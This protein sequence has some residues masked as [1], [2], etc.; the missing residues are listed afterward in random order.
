MSVNQTTENLV[1]Q[2]RLTLIRDPKVSWLMSLLLGSVT[3][4][5]DVTD[6]G[7]RNPTLCVTSKTFYINGEYFTGLAPLVRCSALLHEALHLALKHV[8][9]YVDFPDHKRFNYACDYIVNPMIQ[10]LGYPLHPTWLYEEKYLNKTLKFIYDDLEE[11]GEDDGDDDSGGGLGQCMFEPTPIDDIPD[12]VGRVHTAMEILKGNPTAM[13]AVSKVLDYVQQ[14]ANP[15]LPFK[16][17]LSDYLNMLS[18]DERTW[19]YPNRRMFAAGILSKGYGYGS[20]RSA[21]VIFD[22]SASMNDKLRAL[23]IEQIEYMRDA[24]KIQE[25]TVIVFSDE[26]NQVITIHEGTPITNEDLYGGGGTNM[27]APFDKIEELQLTP[28]IA[29]VFTDMEWTLPP[30]PNYDVLWVGIHT[31]PY[32]LQRHTNDPLFYGKYLELI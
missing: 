1:T 7:Q 19:R 32:W 11:S 28:E 18:M 9:R 27:Q 30:K 23:A 29:M 26:V 3:K 5:A 17:A 21:I 22:G 13:G 6:C 15:P 25:L 20:L 10:S 16:T 24:L 31:N 2:T 4:V 14:A 12:I 8:V